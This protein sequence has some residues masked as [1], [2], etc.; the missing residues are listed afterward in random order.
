MSST[1]VNVCDKIQQ[2]LVKNDTKSLFIVIK[3]TTDNKDL[4]NEN[5]LGTKISKRYN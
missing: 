2:C 5:T 4:R 1:H 3:K